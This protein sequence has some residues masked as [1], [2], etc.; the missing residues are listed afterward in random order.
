[1]KYKLPERQ[2]SYVTTYKEGYRSSTC[3]SEIP[4]PYSLCNNLP[5]IC[6]TSTNVPGDS[7]L[8]T[9]LS[10]W[11]VSYTVQSGEKEVDWLAPENSKTNLKFIA[12]VKLR[13]PYRAN[14]ST[15][16]RR[17][18]DEANG[19][20]NGCCKGNTYRS[21]LFST[22][23]E[24]CPSKSTSRLGG[25]YCEADLPAPSKEKHHVILHRNSSKG[26]HKGPQRTTE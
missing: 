8:P 2:T 5:N 16:F 1:M 6:H 3:P 14:P 21:S 19:Q 17:S 12:K 7:L 15:K 24:D 26:F 18:N 25:Y 23:C 13:I 11:R 9:T 4:N 10:R 22:E 20:P